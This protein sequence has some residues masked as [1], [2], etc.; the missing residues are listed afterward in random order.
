[1]FSGR[2]TSQL[3]GPSGLIYKIKM[4]VVDNGL[5]QL[6]QL[7]SPLGVHW[8]CNHKKCN[9]V[10]IY[11]AKRCISKLYELLITRARKRAG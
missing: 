11:I 8:N 1:M 4:S 9:E 5:S 10:T 6:S 7:P 2:I 3:S